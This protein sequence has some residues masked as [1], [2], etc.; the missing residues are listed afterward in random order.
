MKFRKKKQEVAVTEEQAVDCPSPEKVETCEQL[1]MEGVEKMRTPYPFDF[2]NDQKLKR[3]FV[4]FKIRTLLHRI[5]HTLLKQDC[6]EKD[7]AKLCDEANEYGFYSVCVQPLHVSFAKKRLGKN[8]HV[9]VATV[10]GFPMGENLSS[11]KAKETQKAV[12]CGADE[13]DMV[14]C[15]SAIKNGDYRYVRR[16]VEK[17]VKAAKGRP[18]KVIIETGLLTDKEITRASIAAMQ[19]KA[20]FVKTSTGYFGGGATVEAVQRIREA[21]GDRC[22]IKASGGIRTADDLMKMLSSGADR[23]GTSA[24]VTIAKQLAENTDL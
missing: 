22:S 15:I 2:E 7:L 24:G 21:V 5:D 3:E 8:S 10:I 18:V 4:D 19:G 17:V 13:I 6:T 23:I 9:K 20:T 14:A 1:Q 12:K 11:V 16:D